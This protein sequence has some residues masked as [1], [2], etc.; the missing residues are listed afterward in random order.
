MKI[1]RT[2]NRAWPVIAALV[3][4]MSM[5]FATLP[6]ID[7]TK[8]QSAAQYAEAGGIALPGGANINKPTVATGFLR[9]SGNVA[10]EET[11]TIGSDVYEFDRAEDGV[12]AGRIAVTGHADDTAANATDALIATINASGTENVKAIDLGTGLV[13]IVS[14]E[15]PGGVIS[16]PGSA[17]ATTETCTNAA[18][19]ETTMAVGAA[20]GLVQQV[21]RVPQSEEVTAGSMVFVFPFTVRTAFAVV[22]VTSTGVVKAWD[23][24]TTVSGNTVT[25]DNSGTTDW[26]ATDTVLVFAAE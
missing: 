5:L 13:G 10:D 24:A 20:A 18:W 21:Q 26:A 1:Q 2:V 9:V 12:T 25:L 3:A 15:T 6:A 16:G 19:D 7:T 17:L 23:G 22:R 8:R 11:V 14:A 4:A